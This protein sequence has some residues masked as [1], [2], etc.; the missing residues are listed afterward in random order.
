[1][2]TGTRQHTLPSISSFDWPASRRFNPISQLVSGLGSI[3]VRTLFQ[4]FE[5]AAFVAFSKEQGAPWGGMLGVGPG[6]GQVTATVVCGWVWRGDGL[7]VSPAALG[8]TKLLPLVQPAALA[9]PLPPSRHQERF[10]QPTPPRPAGQGGTAPAALRRQARLLA[11]LVRCIT[12]VG[13]LAAAF[14]PA[15]SHLALLLLYGRRWADTE[16]PLALGL[17]SQYLV[18]LAANGCLEAFVHSVASARQLAASNAWLVAFTAAHAGLSIA[19]VRTGGAAG[20]I[21]ADGLNML[22]RIAYCLAFT[23]ARF[24]EVPGFR[25]RHLLPSGAT[26]AALVVAAALTSAS[27]LALLPGSSALAAA[28]AHRGLSLP[29]PLPAALQQQ[30]AAQPF[31]TLAAAHVGVGATCLAAVAAVAARHERGILLEVRQLRR[32]GA[33]TA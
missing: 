19:A 3:V 14:G 31:S 32:K 12:L 13:L 29:S 7:A 8:V 27:R 15:Y 30:L 22:L 5:E 21:A 4:P 28:A 20:L 1:M 16:A 25:L 33:K 18:L 26:A 11:V 6:G 23:K 17:Y 24:R 10:V 9:A 2:C